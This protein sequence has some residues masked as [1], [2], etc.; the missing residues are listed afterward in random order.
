[1]TR[2]S[3]ADEPGLYFPRSFLKVELRANR[4]SADEISASNR[5]WGRRIGRWCAL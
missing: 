1:M 4:W 3:L 5:P 2:A